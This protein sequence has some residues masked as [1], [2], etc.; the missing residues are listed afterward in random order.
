MARQLKIFT[1]EAFEKRLAFKK[2]SDALEVV[3][4][5][6]AENHIT[7]D[8]NEVRKKLY[9]FHNTGGLTFGIDTEV[10]E[11]RQLFFL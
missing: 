6:L 8:V 1:S 9:E 5:L 3:P 11:V 7:G 10:K 4:K 2:F